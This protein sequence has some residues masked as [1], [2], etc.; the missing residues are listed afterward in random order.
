[1][2][3]VAEDELLI[4]CCAVKMSS[5]AIHEARCI[6][7][8]PLN[9]ARVVETSILHGVA[10]LLYC[11][12]NQV[13]RAGAVDDGVPP[14]ILDEL[15]G[16]YQ[17]SQ[18][19]SRRVFRVVGE[20]FKAFKDAG[21]EAMALKDVHLAR[22]V[23]PDPSLRP[24]GD[25]DILIRKEQYDSVDRCLTDIGFIARVGDPYFTLKYG[26]G[27]HFRRPSDNMWADV[28]WNIMQR[29]WDT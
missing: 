5:E 3:W 11:G 29:E 18:A 27:H 23:F 24:M 25:I 13:T 20:M 8:H 9:W 15:Q 16:L 21:I 26:L 12:L 19:R 14:A 2:S 7:K 1:M 6:L 10:P 28:Q 4:H 22:A 17:V